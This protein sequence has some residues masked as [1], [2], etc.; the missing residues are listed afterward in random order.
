[1]FACAG[2]LAFALKQPWAGTA[3]GGAVLVTSVTTG[4]V[5]RNL[6]QILPLTLG[7]TAIVTV[8][9][10]ALGRLP[11]RVRSRALATGAIA[12]L[13]IVGCLTYVYYDAYLHAPGGYVDTRPPAWRNQAYGY[14][15]LADVWTFIEQNVPADATVAYANTFYTY[16]LYGFDLSR[17][18]VYVPTRANLRHLHDLP[19]SNRR[20]AGEEIVRFVSTELASQPDRDAWLAN[21]ARFAPD[22]LII[23]KPGAGASELVPEIDFARQDPRRFQPVFVNDAGVVYRLVSPT[24]NPSP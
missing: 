7:A 23:V 6:L 17:R 20:L 2:V 3:I 22:Y 13:G 4:F 5:P 14:G 10:L 8:L 11:Q 18:V 15:A 24:T 9:A 21:F 1:M 16:P 12:V 19:R